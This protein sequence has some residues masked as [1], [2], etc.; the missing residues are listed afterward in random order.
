MNV[1][2]HTTD[3]GEYIGDTNTHTGDWR[4]IQVIATAVLN[5][6]SGNVTGLAAVSL[7]AGTII[8]GVFTSIDLTSGSLIAY[9]R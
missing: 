1:K 6:Y 3:G 7:P 2:L 5:A 9:V 8:D 4:R